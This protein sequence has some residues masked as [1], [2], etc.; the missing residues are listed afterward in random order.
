MN[1][2]FTFKSEKIKVSNIDDIGSANVKF[3]YTGKT[4]DDKVMSGLAK[5]YAEGCFAINA[6]ATFSEI[7]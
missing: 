3:I 6:I 2:K 7:S 4:T 5:L 1:V